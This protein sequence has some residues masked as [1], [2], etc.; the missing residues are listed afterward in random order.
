MCNPIFNEFR[1]IPWG[2]YVPTR[3]ANIFTTVAVGY[4]GSTLI[5][6]LLTIAGGEGRVRGFHAYVM[7]AEKDG[8]V[9]QG[10]LSFEPSHC[11][12]QL[13]VYIVLALFESSS[14]KSCMVCGASTL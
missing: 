5:G 2:K 11:Q 10:L 14:L 4:S 12:F 1:V 13:L 8:L 3:S 9:R 6:I 7:E